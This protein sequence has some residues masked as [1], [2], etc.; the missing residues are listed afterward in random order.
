MNDRAPFSTRRF[1]VVY[2]SKYIFRLFH[3]HSCFPINHLKN[4]PIADHIP[5]RFQ[6]PLCYLLHEVPPRQAFQQACVHMGSFCTPL[7]ISCMKPRGPERQR[8]SPVLLEHL[9]GNILAVWG[10]K[11]SILNQYVSCF[12]G[13]VPV[14]VLA[15]QT[16]GNRPGNC[17][18]H[19]RLKSRNIL[20]PR[21]ARQGTHTGGP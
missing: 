19:L 4:F 5:R 8:A 12:F 6:T 9:L 10:L 20:R 16:V 1:A 11:T 15:S 17:Q 3:L 13:A 2:Y 14:L 18:I 21:R 7:S